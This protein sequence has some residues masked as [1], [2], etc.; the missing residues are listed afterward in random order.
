MQAAVF[1]L[2]GYS[3]EQAE[4]QFGSLLDALEYGAPPHGGIASG[5]DRLVMLLAAADNIRD[6]IAFPK[7]QTAADLMMGAPSPVGGPA[8]RAARPPRPAGAGSPPRRNAR[9]GR[10]PL[11]SSP[12]F[13][14]ARSASSAW[15]AW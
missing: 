12:S 10:A 1:A 11:E 9:R 5:V 14:P 15:W 2:M 7:N 13:P 8:G 3:D 6:V 4:E